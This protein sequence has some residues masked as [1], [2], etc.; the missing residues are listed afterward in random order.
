MQEVYTYQG[1]L[2][3]TALSGIIHSM[4]NTLK[5][6]GEKRNNISKINSVL[7]ECCQNVMHHEQK[8]ADGTEYVYPI[9]SVSK[10]DESY[11]ISTRNLITKPAAE[12][13]QK[14]I[15]RINNMTKEE[16]RLFH[17]EILVNGQINEKG[18]GGLGIV[19]IA[20]KAKDSKLNYK[21]QPFTDTYLLFNLM[22]SV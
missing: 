16:L 21:F 20:R 6:I 17:K 2:T 13:L 22:V 11:F 12:G 1:E 7:I 14:Y 10:D 15:E 8:P 3:N 18:G 4:E 5:D 9:V 19:N